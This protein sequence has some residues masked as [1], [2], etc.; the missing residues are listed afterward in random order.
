METKSRTESDRYEN[1]N[2][3]PFNV[4]HEEEEENVDEFT[5]K[6]DDLNNANEENKEELDDGDKLHKDVNVNLRKKDV[7]MTDAD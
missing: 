4:K 3:N 6:E 2:F 7:E 1:L 5:D